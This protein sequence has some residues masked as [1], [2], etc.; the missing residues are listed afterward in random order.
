LT[1]VP[2]LTRDRWPHQ[3]SRVSKGGFTYIMANRARGVLYVGVTADIAE[4][5]WLHKTGKGSAFCRRYGIDMLVLVETY[6]TIEEAIIREKQLKNWQREWKV[7]L[8]E[9]SNPEWEDL[10]ARLM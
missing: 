5:V 8:I 1:V 6:P 2:G 9:A 3:N 10:G 7:E 4:R